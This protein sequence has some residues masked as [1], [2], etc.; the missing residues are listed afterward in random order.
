MRS[1]FLSILFLSVGHTFA[2][3]GISAEEKELIETH[4]SLFPNQTEF[5]LAIINGNELSYYGLKKEKG[6]FKEIDNRSHI[7]QIGSISKVFTSQLLLFLKKEGQIKKLDDPLHEYI[8]LP[9]K[10]NPSF[11]FR[12]LASHSS[13][14]PR[15][16]DN[17]GT[18]IFNAKNPNTF[19]IGNLQ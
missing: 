7:F 1:I 10:G 15:D 4:L 3:I 9:L 18:T 14:L 6:E 12:Q 13:G 5:S 2:Q 19:H 8:K 16:P 11:S 17:L